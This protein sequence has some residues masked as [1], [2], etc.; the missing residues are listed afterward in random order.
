[1]LTIFLVSKPYSPIK[2]NLLQM[3]HE[4]DVNSSYIFIAHMKA[5]TSEW[6]GDKLDRVFLP[7]INPSKP[8]DILY[9]PCPKWISL[10]FYNPSVKHHLPGM[11]GSVVASPSLCAT[12]FCVI[13]TCAYVQSKD[14]VSTN[15]SV[16]LRST[17]ILLKT[18]LFFPFEIYHNIHANW[19]S[20]I[21]GENLQYS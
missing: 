4:T 12:V 5:S 9:Q 10:S 15:L 2:N 19:W 21:L 3:W 13:E 16:F 14:F 1:M 17:S 20:S 7:P 11:V 8:S 18:L 6:R